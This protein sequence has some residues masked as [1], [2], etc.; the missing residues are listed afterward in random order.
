MA[1]RAGEKKKKTYT[2][3][4]ETEREGKMGVEM[5]DGL[6]MIKECIHMIA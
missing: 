4:H 3:F 1:R 6:S 5:A 2:A